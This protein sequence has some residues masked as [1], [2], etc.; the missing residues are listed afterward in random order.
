METKKS[1]WQKIF[2]RPEKP[3]ADPY[4]GGIVL[5]LTLFAALFIT[6]SGLGGSGTIGRF[7][8]FLLDL[9]A[10]SFVDR[11]PDFLH[12]GGGTANPLDATLPVMTLGSLI[13]GFVS[14]YR[15]GRVRPEIH[16]GPQISNRTRLTM[17]FLGG[18]L[19]TYGARLARGCTSG[20]GLSGGAV[21]SAGS[22]T[23]VF[24]IFGGA[25]LV[26]YFFR[27]LWI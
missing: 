7:S 4:L 19:F 11:V 22:W 1:F 13:G 23:I 14:G 3:Y 18:L 2:D 6:G 9:I 8:V 26:A 25:Y 20:Q 16:K 17:A 27:K 12:W 24:A 21:L 5:G 15:G 10:P